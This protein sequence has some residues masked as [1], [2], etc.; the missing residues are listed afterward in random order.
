MRK[1]TMSVLLGTL[2]LSTGLNAKFLEKK[3]VEKFN[4]L[5]FMKKIDAK[6]K[7]VYDADS[8]YIATIEIKGGVSSAFITKDKKYLIAGNSVNLKDGSPLTAP[9][10]NIAL[11]KDKESFSF[12]K[13]DKKYMLFTDP[14]CPY[15]KEL[16]KYLP[17]LEEKVN[18]KIY[19]YPI[20]SL[21][22]NAKE[23]SK[24]Q[25]SLK[26]KNKNVLDI[27]SK[28]TSSPDYISRK[29]SDEEHKK[30]DKKIDEQIQL[31]LDLGIAGTPAIIKENGEQMNWV[32][33]LEENGIKIEK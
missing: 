9:L 17:Q 23:L 18:I 7:S 4:D 21:H 28:T 1:S 2:L 13:G 25:L 24:Y 12:G 10:E 31:A 19:H 8:V 33:F 14:E 26:D 32:Q 20:L 15:C 6:F 5:E 22:P 16:E 27:L 30:L 11:A 29:Y 3:E